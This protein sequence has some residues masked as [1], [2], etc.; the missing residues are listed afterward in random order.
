MVAKNFIRSHF[1]LILLGLSAIVTI[2]LYTACNP[3][4]PEQQGRIKPTNWV[5]LKIKFKPNTNEER[6]DSSI[7]VIRRMLLDSVAPL[8]NQYSNYNPSMEII[9]TP[10]T[11]SLHC[12][13]SV[14]NTYGLADPTMLQFSKDTTPDPPVCPAC[15]LGQYCRICNAVVSYSGNPAYSIDSIYIVVTR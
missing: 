9:T 2:I 10:F 3:N 13:I 4:P 8:R 11:D 6:R 15:P 1:N 14:N 5:T 7:K 12:W